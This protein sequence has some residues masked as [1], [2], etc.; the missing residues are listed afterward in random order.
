[1]GNPR[2]DPRGGGGIKPSARDVS[3]FRT[4]PRVSPRWRRTTRAAAR[5]GAAGAAA[6]GAGDGLLVRGAERACPFS[7]HMFRL[8][9]RGLSCS[10][11]TFRMFPPN[12]P[13]ERC[14]CRICTFMEVA[15][16]WKGGRYGY[17]C[18]NS[19]SPLCAFGAVSHFLPC[20]CRPLALK[21]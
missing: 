20:C 12:V 15:H 21:G 9:W 7:I 13:S 4:P 8:H 14:R 19:D 6:R 1:M 5:P 10:R 3:S 11:E 17:D 16:S 18:H 2:Q